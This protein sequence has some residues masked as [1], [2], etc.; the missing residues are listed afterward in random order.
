MWTSIALDPA[1]N[2][3]VAYYDATNHALKYAHAEGAAWR[4]TTVTSGPKGS[5]Y[6]SYAKLVFL[7]GKPVIAFHFVENKDGAT[8]SGVRLA[9]G[10]DPSGSSFTFEDVVSDPT[11]PCKPELCSAGQACLVSGKCVATKEGCSECGS[12]EACADDG[13]GSVT[14]QAI[15]ESG[16][17]VTYPNEVGLYIALAVGQDGGLRIG[18]YDRP[19]GN[20][21]VATKS[22]ATFANLLVDGED[23]KGKNTGD[24]GIGLAMAIDPAGNYHLSYVDGLSEA[25]V[26]AQVKGGTTPVP[27][28]VVDTGLDAGDGHHVVGDDSNIFITQGGEVRI[29]YQDATSGKL[30]LALGVPNGDK[31]AWTRQTVAQEGFAGFFSQQLVIHGDYQ[32][33]N[34]W[35]VGNPLPKGDVRLVA[36]V[37]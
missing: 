8:A 27:A 36:P 6:G 10:A 19:R 7:A 23:G 24:K 30:R 31:H 22:G 35:R 21:L 20:V 34:W 29:S 2:P 17:I 12:G 11:T 28:E 16:G 1:G 26:Y 37:M 25:L 18:Y 32:I 3:A 13:M 15:K 5:D 4:I 33:L 14:C 9:T